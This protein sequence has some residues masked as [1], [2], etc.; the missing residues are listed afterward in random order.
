MPTKI[1]W[2]LFTSNVVAKERMKTV[3]CSIQINK[4]VHDN[5]FN[6]T[7]FTSYQT[8]IIAK[9]VCCYYYDND[10]ERSLNS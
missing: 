6:H 8:T 10:K 5:N 7:A 4:H 2:F 9:T 1:L 3:K